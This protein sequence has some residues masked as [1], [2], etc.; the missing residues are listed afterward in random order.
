MELNGPW[1][2][3]L[4]DDDRR[5]DAIG[6]DVDDSTWASIEVP[7]ADPFITPDGARLYFIS[8]RPVDG[9]ARDDMDV[10]VMDRSANG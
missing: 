6:L 7:E 8:D 2:V 1:R 4:G 5:R 10:W 3:A 9:K